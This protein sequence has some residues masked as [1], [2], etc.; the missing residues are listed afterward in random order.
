MPA[1]IVSNRRGITLSLIALAVI[2]A[3][4]GVG[5]GFLLHGRTS[6]PARKLPGRIEGV[7][8]EPRQDTDLGGASLVGPAVKPWG[9]DA[10]LEEIAACWWKAGDRVVEQI[11]QGLTRSAGNDRAIASLN[12]KKACA[13][14][15]EGKTI[16][17]YKAL[18][19]VRAAATG[20]TGQKLLFTII[21]A[22]GV[23]ALRRGE[24]ENCI[25]C[26]GE[27]SC[28]L[29]IASSAVHTN[30]LGSRTA[31][32]HFTEYL[33]QFPDDLE[34]RWLLNLAH[35]TLGE[36]PAKVHPKYVL[37]I[38][39]FV[40]SEFDI[41]KFRD[42]GELAGVNRLNQAGGAIMDDFDNDGRLDL[43]VDLNGPERINGVFPQPGR[44]DIRGPHRIGRPD[45][46]ARR[47]LLF[48]GGL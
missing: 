38:E 48:S 24:N 23:T 45:T 19:N 33:E 20:T 13:L 26:R 39:K 31:I 11:D 41:G 4:V 6:A 28:I 30:P 25:M 16:E 37:S 40:N 5:Y 43:V 8:Y 17:A 3:G 2:L 22:Q 27:S 9:P 42:V 14:N 46:T 36:H 7:A 12:I 29:P 1:R 44:R 15:Y 32:E 35:M 18:E 34:V 47:T 21:Y 10:T